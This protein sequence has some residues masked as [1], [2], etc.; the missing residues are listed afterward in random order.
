MQWIAHAMRNL[1]A[2]AKVAGSV[3]SGRTLV[4]STVLDEDTHDLV[5]LLHSF[6]YVANPLPGGDVIEIQ[7]AGQA[8]H[9]ILLGGD[10]TADTIVNLQPGESGLSR[11]GQLVLIRLAGVR[12]VS[13]LFQWGLSEA[14]LNRMIT[15]KFKALYNEHTH[16][17]GGSVSTIPNQQMDDSYLTGG[18]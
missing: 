13:P 1:V 9:K 14:A 5:E 3:I 11:G 16:N 8:S 2:R 7:I 6:G 15:E 4:Q 12:V 17:V 18:S 10:N